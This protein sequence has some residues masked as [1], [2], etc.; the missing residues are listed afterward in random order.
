MAGTRKILGRGAGRVYASNVQ[1]MKGLTRRQVEA[2]RADAV[3]RLKAAGHG[4]A[5]TRPYI[6]RGDR[7]RSWRVI[8]TLM[9]MRILLYDSNFVAVLIS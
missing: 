3:E 1:P 9:C 6:G 5:A 2:N 8:Y 7:F 4:V